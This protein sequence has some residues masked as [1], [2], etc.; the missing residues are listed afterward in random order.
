MDTNSIK[1]A[2]ARA[3]P[4]IALIK[5]WGKADLNSFNEPAVAS[6]SLTLDTLATETRVTFSNEFS[7]DRLILNGKEDARK[8]TRISESVDKLRK[9]A[10]VS[11]SCLVETENNFPTG[12]G[13]ASSA[14]GFAALVAATDFA[15]GLK[16]SLREQSMLARSMSGSAARS[17]F[18]G[19]AKIALRNSSDEQTAF[20]RCY[21]EPIVDSGYWPLE[22]CVGI[23]S[24][25]EKSVG[26]TEGM[27][28]TRHT[29]PYYDE[30]IKGNNRDLAEAEKLV[31][32]RDF[33]RLAELSEFSCLKMHALAMA[34]R[35][36]LLYW[37]GA[38]VEA[39]HR[40]RSLRAQGTPVF[41]TIDAGPQIKAIC[42]PGYG[43]AV[44]QALDDVGGVRKV[45]HC[46]L[47]S[48]VS[49]SG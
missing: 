21:A 5:Y 40:I 26:S 42:A 48:G 4:N 37:K 29:S 15:L 20:G 30:W 14:S 18:G 8:L 10:A 38:T 47:G 23:I 33:E 12:A 19:F 6:L 39:M 16:L 2:K 7:S 41:F 11:T 46:G 27:E 25:E 31:R 32:E 22:V 45:I 49:V 13:L 3:H 35:P 1:T 43:A 36:G 24:E 44:R 17:I 9:L 28:R 34:S